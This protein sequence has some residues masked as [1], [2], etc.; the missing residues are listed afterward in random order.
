M[1]KKTRLY[2]CRGLMAALLLTAFSSCKEEDKSATFTFNATLEQ[3]SDSGNTKVRLVNER[4][5]YWEGGDQITVGSDMSGSTPVQGDLTAF[6]GDFSDFNG[7]FSSTLPYDSKYF[8]ALFPHHA[9]NSISSAGGRNFTAQ[10]YLKNEQPYR[11]GAQGDFTF[12]KNV[13]PMCAWYGDEAW[14]PHLDF[15]SMAGIVRLQFY[16]GN[17]N[18]RIKNIT[19]TSDSDFE[20]SASVDWLTLTKNGN[21]VNVKCEAN[22]ATSAPQRTATITITSGDGETETVS[23]TQDAN[24]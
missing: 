12:S 5:I 10:I 11:S 23:V 22:D 14:P 6:G 19:V 16:N 3:P 8:F 2:L 17:G 15:H 4:W 13:I 20:A 1:R 7:A 24:S 18:T 9:S 21:K